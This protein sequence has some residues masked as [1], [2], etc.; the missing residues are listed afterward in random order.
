MILIGVLTRVYGLIIHFYVLAG[1]AVLLN[2]DGDMRIQLL[3]VRTP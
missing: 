3:G 1:Y 2:F